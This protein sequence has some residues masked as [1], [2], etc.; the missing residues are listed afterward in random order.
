[1]AF[2]I[3]SHRAGWQSRRAIKLVKVHP[4]HHLQERIS[5]QENTT[6]AIIN[7]PASSGGSII[8]M[9][10]SATNQQGTR[11]R[12]IVERGQRKKGVRVLPELKSPSIP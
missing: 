9:I 12:T 3:R 11:K 4:R 1:M 7:Q 2:R 5:Y 10:Q 8:D 6:I